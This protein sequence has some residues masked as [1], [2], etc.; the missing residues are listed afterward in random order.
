MRDRFNQPP[1]FRI[2]RDVL[3]SRAALAEALQGLVDVDRFLMRL[4]PRKVFKNCYL[5]ADL[6]RALEVAKPIGDDEE[7]EPLTVRNGI[8][9]GQSRRRVPKGLSPL[10]PSSYS[11]RA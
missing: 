5:G 4:R 9:P 6:I 8:R 7:T 2:E 10:D 11:E 1:I 3:Y